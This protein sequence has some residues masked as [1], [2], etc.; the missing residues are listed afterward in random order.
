[1]IIPKKLM[2][3]FEAFCKKNGISGKE[4]EEKFEQMKQRLERYIYEPGEAVGVVAAQSISEPATQM[5]VDGSEKVIVKYKDTIRITEIGKF[6]GAV[7]QEGRHVDGWDVC[8]VSEQGMFVPSISGCEKI[9]WKRLLA[10]SRHK[11]PERLL[12][13]KTRS[14]RE[15]VAT[16]SHSFVIRRNNEVVPVSGAELTVGIRIPSIRFLPENCTHEIRISSFVGDK[17]INRKNIPSSIPL[18]EAFGF[19]VGA[20]LSEG[21][22]TKN[23]TNISN[24]DENFLLNIRKFADAYG[25]THSE[26]DNFRGFRKGHDLRVNSALISRLLKI[27]CGTGSRNKKVPE[28]AFSADESFVKGLLKGYFEGDGSVSVE[29][30]VIRVSSDSK[31]L[32]DGIA[33]LLTRFGI[34]AVKH[35]S[36]QHWLVVGHKYAKRFHEKIGFVSDR[37]TEKLE[38][39]LRI[40]NKEDYI[41]AFDGFGD[42]LLKTARKLNYPSRYVNSATKRQ[43]I[44][45]EA[46]LRRIEI[47]DALS[48]KNKIDL[49]NELALMRQMYEADVVW[50]EIA[51]IEKVAPSSEYVYDFTVEGT[52]TFATFDGIITHNT[53]RSYTLASQSDRLS[54]VTH[55]LPRLIEIF[56]ARKTF[57]KNMTIY[58]KKEH[59]S[60][61]AAKDAAGRIKSLKLGDIIV[62]DSIDL[63]NMQIELELERESDRD[64]VK[65]ILERHV[66]DAE[67]SFRAKTV[68]VKPKKNSVR[69]LRKTKNKIIKIH[70]AGVKGVENVVVIKEGDDWVIQTTGTNLKKVLLMDEIDV[71]R[72]RTND[73]YQVLDVL[74]VEAARNVILEE[75]KAT[76][77]EQGLDVDVR[78][79]MLLADMMT[80]DGTIKDI[81]RY[82]VSGKKASVLARANFEETK[83]HLVNASFY[84]E[85]DRLEGI[86]ENILVG[87]IAPIGTG[88]V[89]LTIDLEKM[90]SN[91][92]K[93][94]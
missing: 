77:E 35:S 6:V 86:I 14:G 44:G 56:D 12:K 9:E 60:K 90:K 3:E 18:D 78:H 34:F 10:V 61:E 21:N 84:G 8:D 37:K 46:L 69:D 68:Y 36:K 53:M 19:F 32:L 72:T 93:K 11:S 39:L 85:T 28:F 38:K 17:C 76:L 87:Q 42:L 4:K 74:G 48:K 22:A 73:M 79:L 52:E 7:V 50:D 51:D 27:A 23:Y 66:K 29:R 49:K 24:T 30:E 80:F 71:A 2:D 91:L 63:I 26:Y 45:R 82:G 16:D 75:A 31:E 41:D 57:E 94:E 5:S 70:V 67:F 15:I 40:E 33:L 55:G 54:K 92:K 89:K 64:R 1:M 20:Y 13:I 59:N 83:K 65:D 47:F 88:M 25:L 43:K 58:L 81:G 62:Y